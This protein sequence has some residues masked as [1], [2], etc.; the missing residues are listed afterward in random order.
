[1]AVRAQGLADVLDPCALDK[2]AQRFHGLEPTHFA[3]NVQRRVGAAQQVAG[4]A[5]VGRQQRGRGAE[6]GTDRADL[7]VLHG[8]EELMR[9]DGGLSGHGAAHGDGEGRR[10]LFKQGKAGGG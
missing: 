2:L 1:M 8:F 9:A 3:R 7:T 4:R 6:R 5:G 10:A